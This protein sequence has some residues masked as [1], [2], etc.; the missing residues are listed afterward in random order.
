MKYYYPNNTIAM[1]C[2]STIN[3]NR[4]ISYNINCHDRASSLSP[5]PPQPQQHRGCQ[6]TTDSLQQVVVV[7]PLSVSMSL[8]FLD[9]IVDCCVAASVVVYMTSTPL[10]QPFPTINIKFIIIIIDVVIIVLVIIIFIIFL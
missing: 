3:L 4:M 5:Q 10:L 1:R 6:T 7:V 9:L 8:S 2:W